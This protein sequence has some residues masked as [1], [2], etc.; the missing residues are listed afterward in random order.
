MMLIFNLAIGSFSMLLASSSF[1]LNSCFLTRP[2]S[3]LCASAEYP[4]SHRNAFSASLTRFCIINHVGLSG[5]SD[6]M[7]Q[8]KMGKT[9]APIRA[10]VFQWTYVPIIWHKRIPN[11]IESVMV[12][13]NSPRYW[14]SLC[15][16]K[17]KGKKLK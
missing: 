4:R 6:K 10:I 5:T 3:S 17:K 8:D 12:A 7:T 14:G 9:V 11:E 2:S 1:R 15:E 13:S 16:E